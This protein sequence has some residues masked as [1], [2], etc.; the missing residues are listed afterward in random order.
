MFM[1]GLLTMKNL[2]VALGFAAVALAYALIAVL[3]SKGII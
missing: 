1:E 2:N 3:G